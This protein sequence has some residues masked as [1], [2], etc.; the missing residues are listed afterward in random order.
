M[1]I[2]KSTIL[3]LLFTLLL[4]ESMAQ[5]SV[6]FTLK[7]AIDY[8][9]AHNTYILK[10]QLDRAKN[11]SQVSEA[12]ANYLPQVKGSAS[13]MDNLK[14]QTSI[15][16]GEVFGQP[17]KSVAVQFG[18]KYNVT[19]GIDV[20]QVIFDASQIM[21][22]K[23][24]KES[25]N[26]LSL[27][28][29]KTKEQL[30][31]D[32][33]T[34][35]YSAQITGIQKGIVENNLLK[36]DSLITIT[37]V[38]FDNGFAKKL[39][40]NRLV[41]NRTNTQTEIENVNINYTN[42]LLLLKFY[43][44]MPMENTIFLANDNY[45]VNSGLTLHSEFD[46]N[47]DLQLLHNQNML[48]TLK[49]KQVKAGYLPT[50]SFSYRYAYQVQKNDFK[51]FGNSANWF[52]NSYLSFNLNVPIFDG[53]SKYAKASL[54]K[55]EMEQNKLDEKNLIQNL[56]FQSA[57]STNKLIQNKSSL[58]VQQNNIKLA[59]E[60]FAISQVQFKGGMGT[61]SDLLNAETSLKEAQINYLNALVQIKLAE[62]DIL[63]TTGNLNN[64][65]N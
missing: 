30:I 64:L 47:T 29:Q 20:S 48:N 13:V 56:N 24:V 26:L 27:N 35:Y 32:I 37:K 61:I 6:E 62:L 43:M 58:R 18:T 3:L 65:N 12:L 45:Q 55:I 9:L 33:A 2:S 25:K 17:G 5:N 36:L 16:P 8:G 52:P 44:N 40:Y 57:K 10:G 46:N 23:A 42:Q 41:I 28:Q 51:I 21:A 14:L 38:Q 50:L 39:D 7:N 22:L 60:V 34:A 59:E 31:F 1:N 49:L 53:R 11:E 54:V 19:A 63:K 4:S 15:L